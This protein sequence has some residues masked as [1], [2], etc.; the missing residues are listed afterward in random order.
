[1]TIVEVGNQGNGGK[2]RERK[3]SYQ[4]CDILCIFLTA[5]RIVWRERAVRPTAYLNA[6]GRAN[7]R[8][9]P[10]VN[11]TRNIIFAGVLFC[12]GVGCRLK[13]DFTLFSKEMVIV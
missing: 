9:F 7:E 6:S 3:Q 8:A 1:M 13:L 12:T 11:I 4:R 2:E 5:F 10:V